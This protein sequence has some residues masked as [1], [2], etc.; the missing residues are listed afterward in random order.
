MQRSAA[1]AISFV[2]WG[3]FGEE[4]FDASEI[5]G[6]DGGVQTAGLGGGGKRD[7]EEQQDPHKS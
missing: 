5:T 3:A 2:D 7:Y 6:A 4:R 1:K